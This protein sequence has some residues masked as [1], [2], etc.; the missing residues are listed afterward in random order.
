MASVV[1]P[2]LHGFDAHLVVAD[3]VTRPNQQTTFTIHSRLDSQNL[4]P[5]VDGKCG[6]LVWASYGVCNDQ[7]CVKTVQLQCY[8]AGHLA[9]SIGDHAWWGVVNVQNHF[10]A[11]GNKYRGE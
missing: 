4:Q 3:A 11:G 6:L 1:T 10:S 2:E 9:D 8:N 7:V 5:R